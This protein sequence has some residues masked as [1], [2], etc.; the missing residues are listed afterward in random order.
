M[1]MSVGHPLEHHQ[2]ARDH[3]TKE[4]ISLLSSH[5]LLMVHQLEEG[6]YTTIHAYWN[7]EWLELVQATIVAVS[8]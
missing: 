2:A 6:P 8:A 1:H 4:C 3:T 7:V 5:P